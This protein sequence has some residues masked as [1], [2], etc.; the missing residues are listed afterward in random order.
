MAE[1]STC[2]Y[3][4]SSPSSIRKLILQIVHASGATALKQNL[5]FVE[6]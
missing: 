6:E 4:N 3:G 5:S 2:E 1:L